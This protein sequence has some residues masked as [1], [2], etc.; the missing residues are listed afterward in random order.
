MND[1]EE[2]GVLL[3]LVNLC[4][5]PKNFFF[6]FSRCPGHLEMFFP[7]SPPKSHQTKQYPPDTW[8]AAKHQT[9]SIFH[10]WLVMLVVGRLLIP[11]IPISPGFGAGIYAVAQC[12]AQKWYK[13]VLP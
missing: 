2:M 8:Y 1:E 10:A 4:E 9:G 3:V 13:L 5:L 6:Y 11:M 7:T 12:M